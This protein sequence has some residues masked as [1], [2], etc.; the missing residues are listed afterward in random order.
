MKRS[1]I[2]TLLQ[3]VQPLFAVPSSFDINSF[4]GGSFE[5]QGDTRRFQ[6]EQKEYPAYI[7]GPFGED[8]KTRLV[9]TDKGSLQLVVVWQPDDVEQQKKHGLEKFP[10]VS[11]RIFLDVTEQ[12][13]LDMGPFKNAELNKLREVFGLNAA[14]V[15]WS[16]ADFVGKSAKITLKQSPNKEDANNPFTNV[17]AVS[18]M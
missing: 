10:T 14:G 1:L 17:S 3:P 11:Q 6:P 7:V 18:K 2:A 5:G 4:A 9:V 16:F 13:A 12:G 8:K 15:K